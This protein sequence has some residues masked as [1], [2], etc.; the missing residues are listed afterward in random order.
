MSANRASPHICTYRSQPDM[1]SSRR[2]TT[3][4]RGW[5]TLKRSWMRRKRWTRMTVTDGYCA[6]ASARAWGA[7]RAGGAGSLARGH[8]ASSGA[9]ALS[10]HAEWQ[11]LARSLR[12]RPHS[13]HG[14]VRQ[15]DRTS[16]RPSC[17]SPSRRGQRHV[18]HSRLERV[19]GE[20]RRVEEVRAVH[21]VRTARRTLRLPPWPD[22]DLRTSWSQTIGRSHQPR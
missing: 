21:G 17:A 18:R 16:L 12:S 20:C 5:A 15:E 13:R 10:P 14:C 6:R 2:P 11:R 9:G 8:S 1:Q 7:A 4:T 22:A 19:R 3:R